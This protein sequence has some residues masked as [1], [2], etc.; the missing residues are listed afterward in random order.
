M[1][2]SVVLVVLILMIG[3]LASVLVIIYFVIHHKSENVNIQNPQV[4]LNNDVG[5]RITLVQTA[6]VCIHSYVCVIHIVCT[7]DW[8]YCNY[9]TSQKKNKK[10]PLSQVILHLLLVSIWHAI[11]YNYFHHIANIAE[12]LWEHQYTMHLS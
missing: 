9:Y 2:S 8:L 10:R 11:L 7:P 3:L 12:I 1:V 4:D 5:R 6:K